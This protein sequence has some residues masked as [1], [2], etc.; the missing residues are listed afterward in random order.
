MQE[1]IECGGVLN[2]LHRE[3]RDLGGGEEG[4]VDAGDGRADRLRD[5]HDEM[6][7]GNQA[8]H[9]FCI[10]LYFSPASSPSDWEQ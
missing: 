8:H 10:W 7:P 1:G 2:P 5:V 6:S 3:S 4:K 9:P